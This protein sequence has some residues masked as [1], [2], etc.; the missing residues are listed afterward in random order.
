MLLRLAIRDD[1]YVDT[2]LSSGAA[3]LAASHQD[4]KTHGLVRLASLVAVDAATPSYLAAVEA[5]RDGGATDDEIVG[6]LV[7]LAP[8]VGIARVVSAAPKLGLA[9]GFDVTSALEEIE[10]AA[11]PS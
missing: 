2:V 11:V 3:N 10:G 4:P 5:A 8:I 7:A 6:T 9:L 1:A